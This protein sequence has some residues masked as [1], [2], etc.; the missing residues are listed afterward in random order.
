MTMVVLTALGSGLGVIGIFLGVRP[1]SPSLRAALIQ[2]ESQPKN[3]FERTAVVR[4]GARGRLDAQMAAKLA[5]TASEQAF[6]RQRVLPL[7]R[8]TGTS[9]Q[10]LCR[11]VLLGAG[12]GLVLPGVWWIVLTAGGVHLSFGVPVWAGLVLSCCGGL[13]PLFVLHAR[14]G[15]ARRSARR[16]VGR[17]LNLVVLCLAGGMGIEGALHASA[18]IGEDEVSEQILNALVLAQDGGEPP[19]DAL[20]DLGRSLGISELT[21]LAAAVGL[22]GAEGARIRLT[23]TSKAQSIR[24]HDLAEDEARANSVTER[25]F[26]PGIF[27]LVGFLLFIAYPAVSRISS[28]L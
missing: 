10:D 11:E 18:R 13:L 15:Q 9:I 3:A 26:F 21:E 2:L 20:D 6:V 12:V 27:L 24:R 23:L 16:V 17:F 14:A 19:W 1:A 5:A 25:L 28:G 4:R 7:L 22:A 8:M